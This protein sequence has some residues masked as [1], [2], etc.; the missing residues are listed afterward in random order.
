MSKRKIENITTLPASNPPAK[1]KPYDKT[2]SVSRLEFFITIVNQNHA[3]EVL[4]I[5][6]AHESGLGIITRG[7]GTGTREIYD[8]LG[9]SDLRKDIVFSIVKADKIEALKKDIA[10]FF[11]KESK[12]IAFSIEISSVIGLSIYKYLSNTRTIGD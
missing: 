6:K 12:G 2:N 8:L 10:V 5:L 3:R 4:R 11:K 9:L 7:R 1:F